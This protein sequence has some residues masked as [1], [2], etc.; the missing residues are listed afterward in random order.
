[1]D[2]DLTGVK[3]AN[4]LLKRYNIQ[5]L[6][7]T[8]G[9]FG[10]INYGAKDISDYIEINGTTETLKLINQCKY[11]RSNRLASNSYSSNDSK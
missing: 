9:R 6:F 1:M 3:M 4:T 11:D 2:F 10:T 7:L 8:D 5:P